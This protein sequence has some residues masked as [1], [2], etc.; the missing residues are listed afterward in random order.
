MVGGV[1]PSSNTT[2]TS[3]QPHAADT[4]DRAPDMPRSSSR[5]GQQGQGGDARESTPGPP[6]LT[7]LAAIVQRLRTAHV[8]GAGRGSAGSSNASTSS[9]SS[10][11][12]Q[13]SIRGLSDLARQVAQIAAAGNNG[14]INLDLAAHIHRIDPGAP[15]LAAAVDELARRG[16][17]I[18]GHL[19]A[20]AAQALRQSTD[21][22]LLRVLRVLRQL[23][24]TFEMPAS[25]LT[26]RLSFDKSKDNLQAL[27]SGEYIQ[28]SSTHWLKSTELEMK[29]PGVA[30]ALIDSL[31]NHG[32]VEILPGKSTTQH[33][34]CYRTMYNGN[35]A[36]L[37]FHPYKAG[38]YHLSAVTFGGLTYANPNPPKLKVQLNSL[39][40]LSLRY[41]ELA[42]KN[43]RAANRMAAKEVLEYVRKNVYEPN[44]KSSNKWHDGKPYD[45]EIY[46]LTRASEAIRAFRN[47]PEVEIKD[48]IIPDS[49]RKKALKELRGHNC[50]ELSWTTL[51]LLNDKGIPARYVKASGN[52]HHFILIGDVPKDLRDNIKDWPAEL[53]ICDAWINEA[54]NVDE[55]PEKFIKKMQAW[56][57]AESVKT[58]GGPAGNWVSPT[59]PDWVRAVL[60]GPKLIR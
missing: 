25:P 19:S 46:R 49:E 53:A 6:A 52:A 12:V 29:N 16:L 44:F 3:S 22:A 58:I 38:I 35:E 7:D 13:P 45:Y 15:T 26:A 10:V 51:S 60:E 34:L 1:P 32:Q 41:S 30:K 39:A 59:D 20:D 50:G 47:L 27:P 43:R 17:L 56:Y 23:P 8:P 18:D 33:G 36:E 54:W 21:A 4:S 40:E 9:E 48:G 5:T 37:D 24:A 14:Q 57:D 31:A 2:P 11:E 42:G 28:L 55:Y